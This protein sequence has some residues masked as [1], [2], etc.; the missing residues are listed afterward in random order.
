MYAEFSIRD[1]KSE[2]CPRFSKKAYYL[3][4]M[5]ILHIKLYILILSCSL[6]SETFELFKMSMFVIS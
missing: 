5:P 3:S 6:C 1:E 4:Q 2:K